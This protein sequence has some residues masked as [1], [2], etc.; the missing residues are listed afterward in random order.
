MSTTLRVLLVEDSSDDEFIFRRAL[1][2]E[3]FE[4]IM[5]RVEEADQME[6]ALDSCRWDIVLV[7]Y[8]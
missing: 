5:E 4:P 1:L 3:Q 2:K 7:D 6:Q 8:Y